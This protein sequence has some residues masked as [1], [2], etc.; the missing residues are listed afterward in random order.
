VRAAEQWCRAVELGAGGRYGEAWTVL[1]PMAAGEGRWAS[2]ASS[3]LGSHHRQL[4]RH[5]VG[6]AWD[7]RAR[8]L[9][10]DPETTVE[11]SLGLTAD[12]VGLGDLQ[13]ARDHLRDAEAALDDP[14]DALRR[15]RVRLEW[16]RA[17][18]ALL[19]D[20]RAGARAPA[21]RALA[22]A[23]EYGSDRHV[24][25]SL[26]FVAVS[27][28]AAAPGALRRSWAISTAQNYETLVW[29]AGGLLLG[30]VERRE[31]PEIRARVLRAVRLICEGLPPDVAQDWTERS[32][33]LTSS[34]ID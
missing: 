1:E 24:A 4:G 13:V 11:A 7:E 3:T 14:A 18:V 17:E 25:K 26:L 16:V 27:D 9:A 33:S 20:D 2:L 5:A 12:A 23:E 28:P 29:P 34:E 10:T 22:L 30:L 21:R 8:R 6:R 32:D 19:A 15:V 31:K